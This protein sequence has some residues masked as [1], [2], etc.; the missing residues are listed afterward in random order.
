MEALTAEPHPGEI[1]EQCLGLFI[2]HLDRHLGRCLLY[3]ELFA[4]WRQIQHVIK[5]INPTASGGA[6]EV[7]AFNLHRAHHGLDRS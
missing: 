4:T 3:I 1:T 2:G 6:V 7:R 5:G